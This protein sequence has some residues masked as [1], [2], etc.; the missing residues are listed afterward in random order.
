MLRV[1]RPGGLVAVA[2]PNNLTES[3]LLDSIYE[4]RRRRR[5]RGAGPLS[6]HLRARQ[7]RAREGDNSLG[8]RVPGLFAAQGL[9]DVRGVRQRPG[10]G[11]VPAYADGGTARRHRED[12]RD[13]VGA[14][15]LEL[16]RARHR[17][18]SSSPAAAPSADFDAHFARA[19][20]VAREHRARHGRRHVSRHR[21]RGVLPRGRSKA[22]VVTRLW[23]LLWFDGKLLSR[24]SRDM[25]P[26]P[27]FASLRSDRGAWFTLATAVF[28]VGCAGEAGGSGEGGRTAGPG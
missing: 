17:G 6:A 1:T 28:A 21:R 9:A 7:G 20:A 24:H 2:E 10:D 13:R 19:L 14:P 26:Q 11:V 16:E 4:P 8:D 3:L 23:P 22:P 25:V 12:A 5:H 27:P 18:G 15:L